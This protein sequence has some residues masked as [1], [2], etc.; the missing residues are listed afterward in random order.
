MLGL[1]VRASADNL[2]GDNES[3]RRDFHDGRRPNP[4]L[5]TE[6]RDRFSGPIFTLSISGT[7]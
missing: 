4:I 7:I 5:F 2:L 1:T 3:F 6:Y